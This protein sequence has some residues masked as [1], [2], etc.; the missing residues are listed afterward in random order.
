MEQLAEQNLAL[1]RARQEV[2]AAS[3]R[4]QH[5]AL[6]SHEIR[7]P[8]YAVVA[9]S[10]VLLTSGGLTA[11]QA[12]MLE[13]LKRSGD[14]LVT[15]T[16]D[17]LDYSKYESGRLQL[18]RRP[19]SLRK[20]IEDAMD[21]VFYNQRLNAPIITQRTNVNYVMEHDVPE[22]VIGDVTRMLQLFNNLLSNAAKVRFA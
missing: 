1:Q 3:N 17:I 19:F 6:L 21:L 14:H 5:L 7:T 4:M 11:D 15:I 10:D 16:N 22:I 20:C 9:L 12:F 13:T 2:Q 8:M 18:E